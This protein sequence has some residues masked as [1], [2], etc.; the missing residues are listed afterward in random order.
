M[1]EKLVVVDEGELAEMVII[2]AFN[3]VVSLARFVESITAPE[4]LDVEL[5]T[6]EAP[7]LLLLFTEAVVAEVVLFKEVVVIVEVLL[8]VDELV[9]VSDE[10]RPLR[11][12]LIKYYSPNVVL[13]P[14]GV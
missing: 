10:A 8:V 13:L 4:A 6:D 1:I 3:S 7:E 14:S 2:L 11:F 5:V 9:V 12:V